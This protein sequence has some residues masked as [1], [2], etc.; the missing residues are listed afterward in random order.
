MN[1]LKQVVKTYSISEYKKGVHQVY[2]LIKVKAKSGKVFSIMKTTNNVNETVFKITD[3]IF[4]KSK[5]ATISFLM[6]N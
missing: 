6:K 1:I 3:S 4:R 2:T 5:L